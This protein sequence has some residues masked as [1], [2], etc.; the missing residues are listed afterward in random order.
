[1]PGDLG[2][3][4]RDVGRL[5]ASALALAA[6]GGITTFAA[7]CTGLSSSAD[8]AARAVPDFCA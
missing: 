8:P 2:R 3:R 1:V 6:L 7:I 4:P 5:G